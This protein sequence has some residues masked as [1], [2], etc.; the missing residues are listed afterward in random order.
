MNTA[1]TACLPSLFSNRS[2]SK[3]LAVQSSTLPPIESIFLHKVPVHRRQANQC[4]SAW[5]TNPC[6]S[7]RSACSLRS[8]AYSSS[9]AL[10]DLLSM[11]T[12][13]KGSSGTTARSM[14][15]SVKPFAGTPS[16]QLWGGHAGVHLC[17]QRARKNA[18]LSPRTFATACFPHCIPGTCVSV[19]VLGSPP[20]AVK[21]TCSNAVHSADLIAAGVGFFPSSLAH[22]PNRLGLLLQGMCVLGVGR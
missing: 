22:G 16:G 14:S 20:R 18:V 13:V 1:N 6:S 11:L 9:R 8:L 3:S 15:C 19:T 7:G 10:S 12:M 17:S 21:A 4:S 2:R 5:Q